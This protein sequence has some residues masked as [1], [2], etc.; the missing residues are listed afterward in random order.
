MLDTRVIVPVI[1]TILAVCSLSLT[2]SVL[3]CKVYG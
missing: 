2:V 1:S 3:V